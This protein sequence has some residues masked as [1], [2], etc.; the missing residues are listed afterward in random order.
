MISERI[1]ATLTLYVALP[2]LLTALCR[3]AACAAIYL[4]DARLLQDAEQG[5]KKAK[6]IASLL[7]RGGDMELAVRLF[8]ALSLC[9]SL[10]GVLL[11]L[12]EQQLLWLCLAAL[13]HAVL[14]WTLAV[15]SPKRIAGY[16]PEQLAY[17]FAAPLRLVYFVMTPFL[18]C[19]KLL[20]SLLIRLTGQNP[21]ETPHSV[22]E[23]EIRMLVDEG[24]EHGTIEVLERQMINNIFEFGDRDV[25]EVMTH[26]TEVTAVKI[27]ATLQEI[28][29]L[30][31]ATGYSRM[32]V[33]DD[34][35]DSICGIVYV[36]DLLKYTSCD[37]NVDFCLERELRNPIYIPENASCS[38][39]FALFKR[40][41]TQI[42]VVVD[43]YGG[44]YGIVTMEDLLETIFGSIEDEYD[45]ETSQVILQE[46]GSYLLDGSIGISELEQLLEIRIPDESDADTLGGFLTE[47]LDGVPHAPEDNRTVT[48]GGIDFIVIDCDERRVTRVLARLEPEEE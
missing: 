29:E 39:V 45:N 44:T 20:T 27:T 41:K 35:I 47:L 32:P 21:N 2:F 7:K 13:L 28:I 17:P 31:I 22:T 8:S 4:P 26:R 18:L 12:R 43:E 11:L 33:Y 10:L 38:D 9:F 46:D 36:K 42:A 6:A 3:F 37:R 14:F 1:W 23:E 40:E 24:E 34:D 30:A 48:F 5:N 19:S 15:E 16:F 25:S